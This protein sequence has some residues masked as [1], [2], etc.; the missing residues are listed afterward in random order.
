MVL[1]TIAEMREVERTPGVRKV[2][3]GGGQTDW[4][5]GGRFMGNGMGGGELRLRA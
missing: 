5:W 1:V 3:I 4:E 2:R